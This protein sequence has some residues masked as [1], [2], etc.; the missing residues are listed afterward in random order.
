MRQ[1]FSRLKEK[2]KVKKDPMELA[3]TA[4]S[5]LESVSRAGRAKIESRK[6]QKERQKGEELFELAKEIEQNPE[7]HDEGAF[8]AARTIRILYEEEI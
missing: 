1:R 3:D 4:L 5:K 7:I 6:K 8:K 2:V